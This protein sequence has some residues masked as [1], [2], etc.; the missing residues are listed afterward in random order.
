MTPAT[1]TALERARDAARKRQAE[2]KPAPN[3]PLLAAV[4]T[5]DGAALKRVAV[6]A[7]GAQGEVQAPKPAG[8]AG[9]PAKRGPKPLGAVIRGMALGP[10]APKAAPRSEPKG[11]A[12]PG[13]KGPKYW[14]SA[15]IDRSIEHEDRE[16][17]E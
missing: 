17:G 13:R 4:A 2:G 15:G 6:P 7:E 8:A 9:N 5:Y 11:A 1:L 12:M 10:V 14:G 3:V 16:R